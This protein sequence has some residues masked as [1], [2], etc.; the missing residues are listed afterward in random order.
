M[1][2]TRFKN[3]LLVA[4]DI[5]PDQLLSD[6]KNVKHISAVSSIFP[7]LY[8]FNPEMIILDFDYLGNDLEKVLR[9]IMANKFYSKLKVCCYKKSPHT[10]V[11]SFLR[12]LGVDMIVYQE[13]ILKAEKSKTILSNFSAILDV[14]ILKWAG[15]VSN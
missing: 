14:S 6:Y 15:S 7:S 2:R 13:D 12:A 11:D 1:I 4:P 10:K 3:V 8:T 5:F 9:R